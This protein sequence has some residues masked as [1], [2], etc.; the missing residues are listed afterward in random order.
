MT[1]FQPETYVIG[2]SPQLDRKHAP[3]IGVRQPLKKA[4]GRFVGSKPI[5]ATPLFNEGKILGYRSHWINEAARRRNDGDMTKA[6]PSELV[7]V[8][9]FRGIPARL[10]NEIRTH[11]RRERKKS[12]ISR[13]RA[14]IADRKEAHAS[15]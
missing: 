13:I 14:Q 3:V 10:A 9:V 5:L 8:P 12:L 2:S 15:A 6:K 11:Q 7:Q 1:R 4:D